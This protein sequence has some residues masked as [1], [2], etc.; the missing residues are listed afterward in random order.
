[1]MWPF[2]L[3]L[4]AR[5]YSSRMGM[6]FSRN[7]G[8]VGCCQLRYCQGLIW[9]AW[10]QRFTVEAEMFETMP[11]WITVR[12]SSP[13]DQ[14]DSGLPESRAKVQARAVTRARIAEGKKA[15]PS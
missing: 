5:S 10:S 8:S 15:W 11:R 12:A 7:R 14:R 13:A 1:M 6:A 9:S 2:R 3:K 4:C